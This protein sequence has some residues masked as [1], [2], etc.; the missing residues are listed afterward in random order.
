VPSIATVFISLFFFT[1]LHVSASTG[2]LQ[3]KYIQSFLEAITP[4]RDL[5][6]GY[7]VCYLILCYAIYYNLKFEVKIADNVLKT[8]ILY[9]NVVLLKLAT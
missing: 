9:K 3:V 7:T 5:F 8:T 2:H 6:L 4:T 1:T